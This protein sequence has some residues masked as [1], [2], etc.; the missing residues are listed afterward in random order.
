MSEELL[1][2]LEHILPPVQVRFE[3]VNDDSQG[4]PGMRYVS[5][6]ASSDEKARI[7]FEIKRIEDGQTMA[8]GA[9]IYLPGIVYLDSC[10]INS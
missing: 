6:C 9:F 7:D 8:H 1:D 10:L 3:P 4:V 5:I 2:I